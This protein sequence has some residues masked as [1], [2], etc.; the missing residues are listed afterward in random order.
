MKANY[1]II[2]GK[3]FCFVLFS[4]I[5]DRI[6]EYMNQKKEFGGKKKVGNKV[7]I[8]IGKFTEILKIRNGYNDPL[9]KKEK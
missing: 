3:V 8:H 6:P 4:E 5:I 7:M 2:E 1:L 9:R